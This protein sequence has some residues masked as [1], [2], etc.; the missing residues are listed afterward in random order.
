MRTNKFYGWVR[1]ICDFRDKFYKL[2]AEVIPEASL[3]SSVDLRPKISKIYNQGSLGSCTANATSEAIKYIQKDFLPSRLFIY[4]NVRKREGT[5]KEDS[6]GQI[7]DCIKSISSDGVCPETDCPYIISKFTQNPSKKAY[8][9]AK[10]DVITKYLRVTNSQEIKSCLAQGFPVIFGFSVYESFESPEVAKTGIVEMP[11][12][13][14]SL[15][16][17]HAVLCVGYDDE[18]QRVIVQNSWGKSWGQNGFFTMPYS[19][20]FNSNLSS[21]MWTLRG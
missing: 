7:R 8:R 1:D 17:G 21:D 5:I 13:N 19:Y 11:K 4:Y 16:G 14:E 3:P 15:V 18:T 12:P 6:G 10:N 20:I 9:D 2:E